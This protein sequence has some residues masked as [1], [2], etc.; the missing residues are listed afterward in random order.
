MS[1]DGNRK[2]AHGALWMVLFKLVER[3]LGFISLLILVRLLSPADFGIVSMALSFIFMAELLTAFG[4]DV[5]LIQSRDATEEHYHTAWTCN[6][7][8]GALIT[9]LMIVA[10]GGISDFYKQPELP[11]VIYALSLGPLISGCENIGVVAFRKDMQFRR[12]F[13]FQLSRKVIGFM[14]VVPL[15]YYL[16]NYWALVAGT[17]TSKFA[18]TAISYLAHPFRPHFTLAKVRGLM[19]FSKWLLLNN[20]VGFLKERVSD[21][22]IGRLLGPTSLGMYNVGYEVA[23]MPTTELSAPINRALLPGF[24]RIAHDPEAMRT[25]FFNAVGMLALFAVPAAAGIYALAPLFV[26]TLIGAKWLPA[27][28]LMEILAFNGALLLFHSSICT[29]LIANGHP[30]RVAKTNGLFVLILLTLLGLLVPGY[31]LVGA[32][33]SALGASVLSTPIYLFQVQRSVGAPPSM[34]LSA[35]AR[36]FAAAL[37]MALV[38]RW[39]IP[40]WTP[41]AK[42]IISIAWTIAGIALGMVTYL[43]AILLLWVASGRPSGAERAVHAFVRQRFIK[44]GTAPA[45]TPS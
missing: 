10:A 39:I 15:A 20:V 1:N 32:A 21:F 13:A 8:L 38:L 30:D 12:E 7:I 25:A 14:V 34:F 4:F 29:V 44:R 16:R 5:A 31:G 26:P 18:G 17:L 23:T 37:I 24:S 40:E 2:M 27:V 11:W 33:F 3:S 45:S 19:G 9:A 42:M 28:P 41:E 22:F 36:P 6:V 43:T 35:A